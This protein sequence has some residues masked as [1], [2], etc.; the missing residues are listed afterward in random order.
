MNSQSYKILVYGAGAIGGFFGGKL[1]LSGE[2][3]TFVARGK[4]LAALLQDGLILREHNGSDER[5][6]A[7]FTD[8][9]CGVYDIILLSVKSQDTKEAAER[10]KDNL[11]GDGLIVSLQNG[12]DNLDILSEIYSPS[13][14]AG[15][16]MNCGITTPKANVS[17]YWKTA[18]ITVGGLDEESCLKC[19][20]LCSMFVKAGVDAYTTKD[21]IKGTWVKLMWNMIYNPLS[22][23]LNATCGELIK[24]SDSMEMMKGIANEVAMVANS[25]GIKLTQ[26]DIDYNLNLNPVYMNYKTSTLQD[27]EA[28]K[29]PEIEGIMG[30]IVNSGLNVPVSRTVYNACRFRFINR[31]FHIYPK[32]AA[33][34]LVVNGDSVLLIKRKYPPLGWAIPGGMIDLYEKV[35]DA[36]ARELLEETGISVKASEL[37]LLGVY[38]DPARDFRGHIAST[39]YYIKGDFDTIAGDDAAEAEYFPLDNLPENIAFDHRQVISDYVEKFHNR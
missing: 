19:Q 2:N 4:R 12:V 18:R 32:I 31:W 34:V 9:P 35:E 11:S 22:A 39:V 38:S 20:S 27:V 29:K 7:V 21:I 36:A 14:T 23:L 5:V 26:E 8:A 3:V 16:V 15:A 24:D 17:E 10:L 30:S 37:H 6:E 33:D 1:S 28:D 13:R 25:R